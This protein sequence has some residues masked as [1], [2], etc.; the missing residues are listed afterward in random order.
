MSR[1]PCPSHQ[2]PETLAGGRREPARTLPHLC[3]IRLGS[4]SAHLSH[5]SRYLYRKILAIDANFRLKHKARNI[6]KD[7]PLLDGLAYYV[8]S[9]PYKEHL[10]KG[11]EVASEVNR[12]QSTLHAIDQANSRGHQALNA[13]GIGGV[14][15]ARHCFNQPSGFGDLEKGER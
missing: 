12:C 9:T 13:T 8:E 14:S 15:C 7:V 2:P 4:P 6:A 11:R 10:A 1:M 3:P 5:P